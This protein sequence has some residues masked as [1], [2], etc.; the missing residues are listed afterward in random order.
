MQ[1]SSFRVL[2]DLS[3]ATLGYCGISQESR[4][5]LKTLYEA[6]GVEPTGL[7]YGRDGA[8]VT[9]RFRSG[10]SQDRR[11]ENQALFLEALLEQIPALL[12]RFRLIRWWQRRW[13]EW[14]LAFGRVQTGAARQRV[15]LGRRL[16][17]PAG[18]VPIG[19]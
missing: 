15:L 6:D 14:R 10:S 1:I 13:Q 8:V 11:L 16:A 18:P 9:H 12:L 7:I 2:V 5:L 17:Q 4:L 3:Y 19:R